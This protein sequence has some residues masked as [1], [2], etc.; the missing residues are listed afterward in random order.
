MPQ[1]FLKVLKHMHL[2]RY[3]GSQF[4]MIL[5]YLIQSHW[6]KLRYAVEIKILTQGKPLHREK[7]TTP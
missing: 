4:H 7:Q 3:I 5:Q 1:V 6:R 2:A